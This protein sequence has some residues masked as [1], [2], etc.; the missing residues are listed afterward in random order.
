MRFSYEVQQYGKKNFQLGFPL[1]KRHLTQGHMQEIPGREEK[2][3]SN[4]RVGSVVASMRSTSEI[5]EL[6][7]VVGRNWD[8][9]G[10]HGR[11]EM[12]FTSGAFHKMYPSTSTLL[13][14]VEIS[15][16]DLER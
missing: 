2:P 8:R 1:Y 16:R 7:S 6:T 3:E 9:L 4:W 5:R 10:R 14:R 15:A 12:L 13:A 11:Y